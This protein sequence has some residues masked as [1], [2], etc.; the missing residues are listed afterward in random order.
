MR[1]VIARWVVV[2]L[3]PLLLVTGRAAAQ[4]PAAVPETAAAQKAATEWLVLIDA[5]RY[6]D[7][8]T[9]AASAF[10]QA[11]TEDKWKEAAK[12]A[13]TLVGPLKS[14]ALKQATPAKNPPG[15]PA[16]DYIVF[17]YGSS[18]ENNAAATETVSTVLD[19]DGSCRVVGYFVR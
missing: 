11:V 15:A 18:F 16:G 13:R 14:R 6:G 5:G 17:Q 1:T 8:W 9:A 3:M 19:T 12:A 7:S 2:V 10:K 4:A